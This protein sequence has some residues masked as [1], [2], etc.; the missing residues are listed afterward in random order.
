M[1]HYN[2]SWK[3]KEGNRSGQLKENRPAMLHEQLYDAMTPTVGEMERKT[4]TQRWDEQLILMTWEETKRSPNGLKGR[5]DGNNNSDNIGIQ[6]REQSFYVLLFCVFFLAIHAYVMQPDPV[7]LHVPHP[8]SMAWDAVL[9]TSSTEIVKGSRWLT[10]AL[11]FD[12]SITASETLAGLTWKAYEHTHTYTHSLTGLAC[13]WTEVL[14]SLLCPTTGFQPLS[15]II[16]L[17]LL[18][19]WAGSTSEQVRVSMS[20]CLFSVCR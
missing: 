3:D 1:L 20:D 2:T 9:H 6:K 5:S 18:G 11:V 16:S 14:L 12:A 8:P 7:H 19:K 4:W 10:A 15:C 17:A 13:W